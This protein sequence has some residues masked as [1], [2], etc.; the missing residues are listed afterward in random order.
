MLKMRERQILSIKCGS[1]IKRRH[2]KKAGVKAS[3][4]IL[5]TRE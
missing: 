5:K 2:I 4:D 3:I 1:E